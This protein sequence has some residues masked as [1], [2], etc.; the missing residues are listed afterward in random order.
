VFNDIAKM[1]KISEDIH[2]ELLEQIS[3]LSD[4]TTSDRS[5]SVRTKSIPFEEQI[6]V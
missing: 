4:G 6:D 5:S 1:K 2:N 3:M